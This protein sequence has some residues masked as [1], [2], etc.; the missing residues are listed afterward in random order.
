MEMDYYSNVEYLLVLNLWE[1]VL[2]T[3]KST[4]RGDETNIHNLHQNLWNSDKKSAEP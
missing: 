3:Q 1:H 2:Q 4:I